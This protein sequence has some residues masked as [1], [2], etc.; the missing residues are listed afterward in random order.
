[1]TILARV[2]SAAK[3][4][5]GWKT[6]LGYSTESAPPVNQAP[7]AAGDGATTNED[8]ATVIDVL[9]NDSD[10]G[11]LDP[12]SVTVTSAP[13]NG[14]T[15]VHTITGAIT[16]NPSLNFHGSDSF[17][18]TVKDTLGATSNQA[19]VNVTVNSVNDAPFADNDSATTTT[20]TVINPPAPGVL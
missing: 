17:S 13:T 1:M 10:D 4:T 20:T 11:S 7:S 14:G 8:Q 3:R 6:L 19:T 18:Y 12:A 15:S 5:S 9:I 2:R 16:Y